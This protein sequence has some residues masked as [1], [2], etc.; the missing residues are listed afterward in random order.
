[1][2][3]KQFWLAAAERAGKTFAQTLIALLSVVSVGSITTGGINWSFL[4]G[5]VVASL[6]AAALSLLTSMAST[7]RGDSES[8]SLIRAT[9]GG[10]HS[11]P[12]ELG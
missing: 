3:T 11:A 8:P 10:R 5:A 12:T 6:W 7:A 2:L 4:L 1:M 9:P